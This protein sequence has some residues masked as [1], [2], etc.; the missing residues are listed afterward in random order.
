MRPSACTTRA[1]TSPHKPAVGLWR[2]RVDAAVDV[3]IE[4]VVD[5]LGEPDGKRN[6]QDDQ[7]EKRFVQAPI[8]GWRRSALKRAAARPHKTIVS[9][10]ATSHFRAAG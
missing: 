6:Q 8:R 10:K 7:D 1:E 5:V 2:Q 3:R 9:P 4:A